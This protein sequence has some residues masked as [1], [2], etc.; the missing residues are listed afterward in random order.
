M[1][2]WFAFIAW[3]VAAAAAGL[4]WRGQGQ[5]VPV[6]DAPGDRLPCVS[7]TP[8]RGAESPH[9]ES[10]VASRANIEEDLR[11]LS[12]EVACVRTYAVDQGLDAVPEIAGRHGL[13]VLLGVWIGRDPLRNAQQI[14]VAVRLADQHR[15]VVRAVVVGN[16]VL[17]RREQTAAALR[18][19]IREVRRRVPVPVT[20]AD[21][22]EFWLQNPEIAQ[23]VDI[24][25]IHLL[26]Y[27]ED[28]PIA[29][30]AAI[31]H[32]RD[33]WRKMAAEFPGKPILVGEI[34]WPSEG[35]M[36]EGALPSRVNQ[37][38]FVRGVLAAAARENVDINLIEAFDQPWKQVQEGR[39][40]GAWGM[41]TADREPKFPLSGPVAEDPAWSAK[42]IAASLIALAAVAWAAARRGGRRP[43][44]L[45][46]LAFA[47][48]AEAAGACLVLGALRV[49]ATSWSFG[50]WVVGVG[51]LACGAVAAAAAA[52]AWLA[53][54]RAAAFA[55]AG[56][57]ETLDLLAG[58]PGAFLTR[59]RAVL[60]LAR[61]APLFGAAATTFCLMVDARYRGFPVSLYALPLAA[62][63]ALAWL[64]AERARPAAEDR[65]LALVLAAGSVAVAVSEGIGNVQSIGWAALCVGAAACVA[66]GPG[67]RITP[68]TAAPR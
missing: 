48:A 63:V 38:R 40:G 5:P 19:Y 21:V 13:K 68:P 49:A 15:D 3:L 60:G 50:D 42:W 39:V 57:R 23:D 4:A 31:D 22:W 9:D 36:R 53:G 43:G 55:P 59:R 62:G 34:G 26:P 52:A 7:Y 32:V 44:A 24:V 66:L 61:L 17:L 33:V 56:T 54:D 51:V 6:V 11:L 47:A 37:A 28:F 29:I 46:W 45:D 58:G 12:A 67:G 25:T 2:R 64:S 41:F 8:F 18:G 20:Y 10:F 27:W 65:L 16:E 1:T 35:R 30:G 14:D